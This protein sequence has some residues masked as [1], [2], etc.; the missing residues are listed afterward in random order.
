MKKL[1]LPGHPLFEQTLTS[2]LPPN[3]KR[4]SAKD[5]EQC[6][7]VM[8]SDSGLMEAVNRVELSVYLYGG[9]Y[10]DR[11]SDVEEVKS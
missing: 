11:M 10:D 3:W 5:G 6:A 4:I 1:I 9:E 8:R 2:V 7:F